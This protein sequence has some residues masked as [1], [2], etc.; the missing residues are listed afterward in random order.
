MK[1]IFFPG[2]FNPF[3]KGHADI[4]NRL[5][6]LCEEVVIG[7]GI[8]INKPSATA[9]AE[10][11]LAEIKDYLI[12]RGLQDRVTVIIYSGLS[13]EEARKMDASC[14]ARGIRSA[15]DFDYEFSLASAN[16]EAFG[17]ETILIP[18]DPALSFISSTMIRDLEQHNREDL[19]HKYKCC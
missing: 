14:M 3:T 8:N 16:R 1:K 6:C 13:A 15:S 12:K 19:A 10:K 11:N 5:L 2:S 4:L 9:T 17:I 18:A 7:I